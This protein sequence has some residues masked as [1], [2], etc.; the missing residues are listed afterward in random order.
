[1]AETAV[2]DFAKTEAAGPDVQ[3]LPPLVNKKG[4]ASWA[5]TTPRN[6][7]LQVAAGKFP[8]PIR[9]GQAPRWKR[10]DLQAW[11]DGGGSK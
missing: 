4:T 10:S 8:E 2:K 9:I 11:A 7:E 3:G 5:Q 6:I 1:M